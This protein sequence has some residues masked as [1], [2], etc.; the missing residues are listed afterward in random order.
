MQN[1]NLELGNPQH[2]LRGRDL[3]VCQDST[4]RKALLLEHQEKLE[5]ICA[6]W[7]HGSE[8]RGQ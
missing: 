3:K 2:W 8:G 1:T 4:L 6:P 7:R 5:N